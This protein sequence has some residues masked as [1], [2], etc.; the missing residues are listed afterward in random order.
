MAH[1]FLPDF[2]L[3]YLEGGA[4]EEQTLAR[5]LAALAS[6]RF[7]PHALVDVAQRSTRARCS[8]VRFR[9]RLSSRRP[10]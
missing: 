3:S 5:N 4:E 9:C 10:G 2:A 6:W 1:R 7:V 8:A